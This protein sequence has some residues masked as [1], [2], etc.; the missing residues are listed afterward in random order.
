M[1]GWNSAAW[2][3]RGSNTLRRLFLLT[4]YTGTPL[5]GAGT[6]GASGGLSVEKQRF[7]RR[8]L[9]CFFTDTLR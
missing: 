7:P 6:V 9:L 4:G 3:I 5:P 2:K 8:V 1:S